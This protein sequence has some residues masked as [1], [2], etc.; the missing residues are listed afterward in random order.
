MPCCKRSASSVCMIKSASL[1]RSNSR[2]DS[3]NAGSGGGVS[4]VRPYNRSNSPFTFIETY[5]VCKQHHQEEHFQNLP[6]NDNND[7]KEKHKVYEQKNKLKSPPFLRDILLL[8]F[9]KKIKLFEK[10]LFFQP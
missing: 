6:S 1:C 3:C 5:S 10:F 8:F 4:L 7:A 2:A 9:F